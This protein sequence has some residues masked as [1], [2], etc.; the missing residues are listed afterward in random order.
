MAREESHVESSSVV[1]VI[2]VDA[3]LFVIAAPVAA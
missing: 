3:F 2:I 1:I